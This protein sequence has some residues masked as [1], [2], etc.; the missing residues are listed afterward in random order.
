M[1]YQHLRVS[2][3]SVDFPY[4]TNDIVIDHHATY[5]L[6]SKYHVASVADSVLL[7]RSL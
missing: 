2:L 4:Y 7:T 5:L 3:A 6:S 1:H